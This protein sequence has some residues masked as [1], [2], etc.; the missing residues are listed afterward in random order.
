M[1]FPE[2]PMPETLTDLHNRA[3]ALE[4][5]MQLVMQTAADAIIPP[6]VCITRS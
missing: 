4:A 1:P 2:N 5:Q 6:F 3:L